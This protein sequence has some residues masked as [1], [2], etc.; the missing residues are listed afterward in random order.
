MP[1][2]D[3][4]AEE[5][6]EIIEM[7]FNKLKEKKENIKVIEDDIRNLNVKILQLK[8]ALIGESNSNIFEEKIYSENWQWVKKIK[9]ALE[10]EKKPLTA[11][12]IFDVLCEFEPELGI[13]KR[14]VMSSI[15][16]TL[17][18]KSGFYHEK[19]DFIKIN[20]EGDFEY[21]VWESNYKPKT[22][23]LIFRHGDIKNTDDLPF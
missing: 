20:G 23:K 1:R 5:I 16:G 17:S 21:I 9:F 3:L 4:N 11:N 15:S 10:L 22:T 6:S 13:D 7:H 19:K 12:Q 18:S 8:Q 2:I 14:K